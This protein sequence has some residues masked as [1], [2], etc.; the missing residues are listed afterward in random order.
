MSRFVLIIFMFCFTQV[1]IASSSETSKSDVGPMKYQHT[2]NLT[3]GL[4]PW[5]TFQFAPSV[6]PKTLELASMFSL[7]IAEWTDPTKWDVP[8]HS[9]NVHFYPVNDFMVSSV[10]LSELD[11]DYQSSFIGE[12]NQL[13]GAVAFVI[14]VANSKKVLLQYQYESSNSIIEEPFLHAEYECE[15]I[16]PRFNPVQWLRNKRFG[17]TVKELIKNLRISNLP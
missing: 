13:Q 10:N 7:L 4:S 11:I 6:N 1:E 9:I 15:N 14:F 8:H 16:N 12:F 5:K 17:S 2:C 3:K